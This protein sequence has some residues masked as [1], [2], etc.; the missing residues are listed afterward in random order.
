[1]DWSDDVAYSVHDV[2]DAV[3]SGYVQLGWLADTTQ[4]DKVLELTRRWYLPGAAPEALDAALTR[5]EGSSLWVRE[6][7][8]SRRDLARLKNMTS[9][10]IGRFAMSAVGATRDIYGE[11]P[12]TRYDAQ[13]VVPE[14]T[15]VEIAVLKGIATTYVITVRDAQP[16]YD[17]QQEVLTI[18]VGALMDSDGRF[19]S[20]AFAADWRELGEGPG[21]EAARLR[22]VVDQIA[23]LTDLSAVSLHDRIRGT[24][25]R[26][27]DKPLW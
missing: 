17:N 19:L 1:M 26:V 2:E 5:L 25:W 13:L 10:L 20:P 22:L 27:G 21:V 7:D 3:A 8:G 15:A 6:M 4:R 18:L 16:I 23:S 11:E 12:L 14:D 9:Q 24:H